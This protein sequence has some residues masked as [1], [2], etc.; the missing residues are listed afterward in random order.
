[1]QDVGGSGAIFC[2][3]CWATRIAEAFAMYN[4]FPCFSHLYSIKVLPFRD[5]F[6]STFLAKAETNRLM[7][8]IAAPVQEF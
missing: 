2:D 1:M 3:F 7:V 6:H 4:V 5:Y 8:A